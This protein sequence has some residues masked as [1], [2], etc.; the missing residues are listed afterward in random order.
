MICIFSH[1]IAKGHVKC[2]SVRG[3]DRFISCYLSA[4]VPSVY[5]HTVEIDI[6]PQRKILANWFR[7]SY[8]LCSLILAALLLAMG[9][10]L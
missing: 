1:L 8:G 5:F 4:T 7:G 6:K 10:L 3:H 9:A 2:W